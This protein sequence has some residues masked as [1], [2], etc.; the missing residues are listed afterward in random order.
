[1]SRLRKS[2]CRYTPLRLDLPFWEIKEGFFVYTSAAITQT[3][4]QSRRLWQDRSGRFSVVAQVAEYDD[5]MIKLRKADG[6]IVTVPISKLSFEEQTIIYYALRMRLQTS[7]I[8][9]SKGDKSI[10]E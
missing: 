1:M 5:E 6:G 4:M 8:T 10:K 2:S 7:E 9:K 3:A